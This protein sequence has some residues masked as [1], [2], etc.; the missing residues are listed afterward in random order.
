MP[1]DYDKTR[2]DFMSEGRHMIGTLT[3]HI[4]NKKRSKF[5]KAFNRLRLIMIGGKPEQ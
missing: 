1:K 2:G 4:N 3:E 5:N